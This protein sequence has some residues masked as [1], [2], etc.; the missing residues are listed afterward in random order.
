M[1]SFAVVAVLDGRGQRRFHELP[2]RF[3]SFRTAKDAEAVLR[4]LFKRQQARSRVT[5]SI[6]ART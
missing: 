4:N 1:S 3:P 5:T 6:D 2:L